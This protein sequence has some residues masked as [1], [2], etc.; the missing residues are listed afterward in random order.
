M[1]RQRRRSG[2]PVDGGEGGTTDTPPPETVSAEQYN[3]ALARLAKMEEENNSLKSAHHRLL[4]ET[5]KAKEEARQKEEA[6]NKE[7][8]NFEELFKSSEARRQEMEEELNG[9]RQGIAQREEKS[10]AD[11]IAGQLAD[12]PNAEIMSEFIVKRLRYT[13]E[14][15]KVLGEDGSLTVS[16]VE[17]LKAEFQAN[18]KFKSLLRGS[19]AAGGGAP[20]GSASGQT[21]KVITREQYN[22]VPAHKRSELVRSG[23]KVID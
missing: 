14:G 2:R 9:M 16:T 15:I 3:D 7:K 19:Q 5:K 6:R 22:S 10:H 18:E 13:D 20:G 17:Q 11:I 21:E 8:G 4:G 1:A 23:Y 12:G